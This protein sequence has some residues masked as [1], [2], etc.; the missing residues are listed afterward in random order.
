[1]TRRKRGRKKEKVVKFLITV[2]HI[3]FRIAKNR[4]KGKAK[5]EYVKFTEET[6]ERKEIAVII[7]IVSIWI[8]DSVSNAVKCHMKID[9]NS[10]QQRSF[11][12]DVKEVSSLA[13]RDGFM[14]TADSFGMLRYGV[15]PETSYSETSREDWHDY[16]IYDSKSRV[17]RSLI[18]MASADKQIGGLQ[19]TSFSNVGDNVLESVGFQ[20]I[21]DTLGGSRVMWKGNPSEAFNPSNYSVL[22][23]NMVESFLQMLDK[24]LQCKQ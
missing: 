10:A 3:E 14:I 9:R 12:E 17:V 19:M 5:I 18:E 15:K 7:P 24:S 23:K 6:G 4:S 8:D 22:R 16:F 2:N 13:C 21:P 11:W 20:P 1:M